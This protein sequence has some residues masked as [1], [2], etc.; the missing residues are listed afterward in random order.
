MSKSVKVGKWFIECGEFTDN[1]ITFSVDNRNERFDISTDYSFIT[2]PLNQ[3]N[4]FVL[5]DK[6][7]F[8]WILH[9]DGSK[10]MSR[11]SLDLVDAESNITYSE[12][13]RAVHVCDNETI[14]LYGDSSAIIDSWHIV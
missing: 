2:F 3:E 5:H 9:L 6:S 12:T 11:F 7:G 8:Y 14:T 4:A 10:S 13:Y 1:G